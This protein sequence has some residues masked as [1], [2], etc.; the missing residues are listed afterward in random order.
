MEEVLQNPYFDSV[1]DLEHC[2]KY[3]DVHAKLR[4]INKDMVARQNV[5]KHDGQ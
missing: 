3:T 2:P 5:Y 1:R 4:D